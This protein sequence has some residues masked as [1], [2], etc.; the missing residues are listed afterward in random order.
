MTIVYFFTLIIFPIVAIWNVKKRQSSEH[1]LISKNDAQYLRGI[2]ACF[3]IFAHLYSWLNARGGVN[4]KIYF[5]INQLGGVGVLIFFF[6]SGYGIY[7]S[8]ANKTPDYN[9]LQKR[10]RNVYIPYLIT[11]LF[12]FF[13]DP[14]Y[15]REWIFEIRRVIKVLLVEDWFIHVILIQYLIFFVIWKF[16]NVKND[17]YIILADSILTCI[18]VIEK[19]PSGWSN[20]LWL[21]AFGMICSHYKE[22][23]YDFLSNRTWMKV[24]VFIG[25]FCILGVLF[26]VNKGVSWVNPFK[27]LSGIFLCLALCGLLINFE[28]LSKPMLYFGKRSLYLYVVHIDLL[29]ILSMKSVICQFWIVWIGSILISEVSYR[30]VMRIQK[31]A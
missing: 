29:A 4:P 23:L 18:F 24:F 21:F 14:M 16:F 5:G 11:K 2:S 20:A 12:L 22:K 31:I 10:L 9:Y 28:C 3:V 1:T 27:T 7:S 17:I 19:R 8:Y 13:L 30:F 25:I 26:A 15:T 6:V